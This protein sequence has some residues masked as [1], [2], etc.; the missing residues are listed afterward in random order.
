MK[1]DTIIHKYFHVHKTHIPTL[2]ERVNY[3]EYTL[4]EAGAHEQLC[5]SRRPEFNKPHW[6]SSP[7]L[8]FPY[9]CDC[10]LSEPFGTTGIPLPNNA[11]NLYPRS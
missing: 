5:E 9:D 7:V 8:D 3:L 2:E 10:W 1:T 6:W 4:R 11:N